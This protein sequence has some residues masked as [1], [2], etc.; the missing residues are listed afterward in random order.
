MKIPAGAEQIDLGMGT[1]LPGL[2]EGHNHMFKNGDHPG[3][4]SDAA[5]PLIIQPRTLFSMPYVTLLAAKNAKLDLMS[6][7]TT[8]RDLSSGSTADVDLR[9]AIE[10]GIVEGPRMV[11]ATE[12]LRG[13]TAGPRYA[14]Q[15][16]SVMADLVGDHVGLGELAGLS[17]AA[18]EPA[19][20]F[21]EERGVE[22]NPLVRERIGRTDCPKRAG[23]YQR[24]HAQIENWRLVG[25]ATL[26]EDR[27][28]LR[29][30]AAENAGDEAA[31]V[32]AERTGSLAARLCRL[33]RCGPDWVSLRPSGACSE[34]EY[35]NAD[36]PH[37]A[38]PLFP[39]C[40]AKIRQV[41]VTVETVYLALRCCAAM[42]PRA[43]RRL[44]VINRS[45]RREHLLSASSLGP[46]VGSR[47][48]V[49]IQRQSSS[50]PMTQL[51]AMTIG[52]MR[53]TRRS[54]SEPVTS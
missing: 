9:D 2:I 28:P 33:L 14:E 12:G 20:D 44:G 26:R 24:A 37:D 15:V 38:L 52:V 23:I 30:G 4:G 40:T 13:S 35:R 7:F 54:S 53:R 50:S 48:S 19:F 34:G 39:P 16:L 41:V 11:V 43:A 3:T 42:F 47:G 22:I 29:L 8:A 27:L 17:L 1:V 21:A 18:V 5:V 6:G 51:A 46:S 49:V 36:R 32:I 45:T 25:R 31:G 10:K